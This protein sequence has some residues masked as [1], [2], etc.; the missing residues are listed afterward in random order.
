MAWPTATDYN[1]AVQDLRRNVADEELRAGQPAL[2]PLDLPMIWS[3]GFADVYKIHAKDGN[4]WALKCF[5]RKVPGQADRYQNISTHLQRAGLPFMVDFKYI[6]Q[7]VRVHGEW[8][9][10]L[11]M[12]WVEGGIQL[13]QFVEQYLNRPRTLKL[14]LGLWVK[15]AGRLRQEKIAHADLQHGNVLLVPR[16]DGN[17]ALRLID[18]DGMYLPAFAGSRSG[19]LGHSA[20]QHPQ[21]IREG[22]YS[23][24]VDRFSNLAI[25]S[26]IHCLTVGRQELWDRFDNGDNLLFREEDFQ[27]PA[28][29]DA[30]HTL[31]EL[32]D[33]DSRSLVGR[34]VLACD[35]PLDQ[36]PLLKE[37]ANGHVFP[38]TSESHRAVNSI[39]GTSVSFLPAAG[40]V[41]D[42]ALPSSMQLDD[43]LMAEEL[44]PV[45]TLPETVRAAKTAPRR[46]EFSPLAV[47]RM[48]DGLLARMVGEE[49][50]IL[51]NF[52]RL[53]S[54]V[55]V[56]CLLAA[57]VGLLAHV[58]FRARGLTGTQPEDV[59]NSLPQPEDVTNSLPQPEGSTNSLPQP[60][61]VTNS[62]G[63]K[64]NLIQPGEFMMGSPEGEEDRNSDEQHHRVRITRAFYLGV[65]EVTQEQFEK[66][67]GKNPSLYKKGQTLPVEQ[68]SWED[69]T[70]FC[71]KLSAMDPR[72]EY[73]LPT[74]AEWEYA[75]RA[76]TT[77]RYSCGDD[78]DPENAWF[79][80]NSGLNTHPVGQTLPNAW[81]LY[82]MC[83][84]VAEWCQDWYGGGYYTSSPSNDPGGPTTGL[85]R[86]FRGSGSHGSPGDCRSADRDWNTPDFRFEFLGFRVAVVPAEL[87]LPIVTTPPPKPFPKPSRLQENHTNSLGMKFNLI[88]PG[89]FL[90]G[91]PA[92]DP[93]Q[94]SGETPQHRV[95]ITKPYYLGVYEVTQGEYQKVMG[96]NP[97][98]FK[99][100]TRPVEQVSWEDATEFCRKLS[101]M[102]TRFN[103]RLPT[104]AEWEYACRAGTTTRYICG[105]DLDPD[106]G[107]F[108]SN[109]SS[110]THPVGEKRPNAWG[111]YDMHGN[112]FEWCWDRYNESYYRASP[113]D[114]PT[115]PSLGSYRVDRGGSWRGSA[116]SCR[117]ALRLKSSPG[118][119][120]DALGFRVA[121][122]PVAAQSLAEDAI[123]PMGP[124]VAPTS[125]VETAPEPSEDY[126]N[127]IGIELPQVELAL[128]FY[129]TLNGELPKSHDEF[130]TQVVEAAGITLP[131]LEQGERYEYDPEKGKLF[132]RK[133]VSIPAESAASP[134]DTTPPP[135][136][137]PGR[138]KR[139]GGLF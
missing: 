62:I 86:V 104:E 113:G 50:A 122:V 43:L 2:T 96:K 36:T 4:A 82:D 89:E 91:S 46:T 99:G 13:N 57:V 1:E 37:V 45:E 23:A 135:K 90:M 115:G 5:T 119:R 118:S 87:A 111:L 19:E 18:Y 53:A 30:F 74:E 136:P 3:G 29:S 48:V 117:S 51:H 60:E 120:G 105:D 44:P 101:Q 33:E 83:G 10:A 125:S 9:P 67:M 68:V 137:V 70:A 106:Y 25:Y 80:N 58:T 54:V 133:Q 49:N 21:R 8:Y 81:G 64:F 85:I 71:A 72:F 134:E 41:P 15:M 138:G 39:L 34:L 97:S 38:L 107:W 76:G 108:K 6:D 116:M 132:L 123:P 127:R 24:E 7:G 103:Y 47:P 14:F 65:H 95:R 109:S 88:Q 22:I 112:V 56:V 77:T 12:R 16:D 27:D 93:D 94:S 139:G 35:K 131:K 52:L 28:N 92:D 126:T 128:R 73:R 75:C 124:A 17:L 78:L 98:E 63:M 129:K 11:K 102:D 84:N 110:Q 20:F 31:W 100:L 55:S 130:M 121:L 114:D 42:E 40:V 32:P 66:V 26:A 69:A 61:N 59:A 79:I